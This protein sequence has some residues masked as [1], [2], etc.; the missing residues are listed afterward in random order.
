MQCLDSQWG[1]CD[2]AQL[3]ILSANPAPDGESVC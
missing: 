3:C 2:S 1:D